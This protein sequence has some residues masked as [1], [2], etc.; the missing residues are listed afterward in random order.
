ML[1]IHIRHIWSPI[2]FM[3]SLGTAVKFLHTTPN[4]EVNESVMVCRR[5]TIVLVA[6]PK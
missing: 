5:D 3:W 4:L 1:I 2:G 6:L